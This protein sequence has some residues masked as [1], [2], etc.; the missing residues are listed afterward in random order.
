METSAPVPLDVL[1]EAALAGRALAPHSQWSGRPYLLV[2]L[3]D[4]SAPFQQ[5]ERAAILQ[6]LGRQDCPVVG[7]AAAGV[8]H[9]M[10]FAC[11]LVVASA[12]DAHEILTNIGRAPLAAL[13]LVQLLRCTVALDVESALTVESFAYATLQAGPEFR[14]WLAENDSVRKPS[15]TAMGMPVLIERRGS[16]VR[17]RLNRP[18]RRNALSVEMRDALVEALELVAADSSIVSVT[19]TGEGKCF[20]AGGDLTEFGTSPDPATAHAVRSVRSAP[21]MLAR[22]AERT[23]FRVHGASVGA[24]VELAAFGRRVEATRD[25]FFQLP[26]IRFGL[27]PGSGGCVS[28]PRRI[29]RLRT[30]YLALSACPVDAHTAL[31]WGL[32]DA[33]VESVEFENFT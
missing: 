2:E 17:L 27:I 4:R 6:W 7:I 1:L 13:V 5:P 22:C 3:R 11:D 33:L 21:A 24:G 12:A 29:G 32:V 20:S 26:E 16:E 23:R 30:A 28:I 15:S 10:A 9:P 25:A 31:A 18:T 8:D 19:I 14:S